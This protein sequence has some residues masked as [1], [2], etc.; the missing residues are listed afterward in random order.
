MTVITF[1]RFEYLPKSGNKD[2]QGEDPEARTKARWAR[3]LDG[4]SLSPDLAGSR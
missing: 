1:D 3:E 2:F 4:K